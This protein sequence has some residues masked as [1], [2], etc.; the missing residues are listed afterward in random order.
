MFFC[1]AFAI[2]EMTNDPVTIQFKSDISE[3]DKEYGEEFDRI[4]QF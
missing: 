1:W 4:F 3:P 2:Y